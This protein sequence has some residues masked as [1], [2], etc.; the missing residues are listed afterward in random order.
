MPFRRFLTGSCL[1]ALL[2]ACH[3]AAALTIQ[4]VTATPEITL[5]DALL[6]APSGI[7]VIPASMH[8][9][10]STAHEQSATYRNFS[11]APSTGSGPTFAL[12]DGVLLTTGTAVF[13][14]TNTTNQ[15][16]PAI[17]GSGSNAMLSNLSR[18]SGGTPFIADANAL[19]FQFTVAPGMNAVSASFLFGTEEFPTQSVTDIFG[20]FVDGVNYAY[21]PSG[22]L[23]SNTPGNATNFTD[24][25]VGA[26]RYGVEY[27]GLSKVFHVAGLLDRG[28][29]MHTLTIAIG[30]TADDSFDSGVFIGGLRASS[31]AAGGIT[32]PSA[33]VATPGVL[34]LLGAAALALGG[35]R[36]RRAGTAA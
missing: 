27:N 32:D 31:F 8:Y 17:P 5:L 20:F 1:P 15:Y 29:S 18:S 16:D 33:V 21:F 4:A 7:T 10:G 26:D 28:L 6:A 3:S 24:N 19:S 35:V 34:G 30:D 2:L 12:P 14:P 36:R 11:L 25:P 23:I 22:E 9:Q 13:P